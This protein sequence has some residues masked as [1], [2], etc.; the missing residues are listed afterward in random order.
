MKEKKIDND[1]SAQTTGPAPAKQA[2]SP[3]GLD[4]WISFKTSLIVITI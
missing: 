4:P 3:T 2:T 1:Q